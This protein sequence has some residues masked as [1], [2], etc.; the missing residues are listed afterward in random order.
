MLVNDIGGSGFVV[1]GC[2]VEG[3]GNPTYIYIDFFTNKSAT[4]FLL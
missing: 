2:G 1:G 4:Q 3:G